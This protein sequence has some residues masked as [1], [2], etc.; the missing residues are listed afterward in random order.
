[1]SWLDKAVVVVALYGVVA[2]LVL[3]TLFG[4]WLVDK[5]RGRR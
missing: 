3:L 5:I 4:W 1:M 2:G